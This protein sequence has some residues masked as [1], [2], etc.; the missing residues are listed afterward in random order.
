MEKYKKPV[1]VSLAIIVITILLVGPIVPIQY[2]VEQ[3][4]TR[5]LQYDSQL[6]DKIISGNDV[7]PWFVNVTNQDSVGGTFSIVMSLWYDNFGELQLENT[8]SQSSFIP[9]GAAYAFYVPSDWVIFKPLYS[10]TYSVS[11]PNIQE[12]YNITQWKF[13]SILTLLEGIVRAKS[14]T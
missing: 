11:G 5:A 12:K 2:T 7:G 1:I 9:G 10:F 13:E 8:S 14:K 6:Y 3:T 4:R